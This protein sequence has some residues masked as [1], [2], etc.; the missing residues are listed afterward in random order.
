MNPIDTLGSPLGSLAALLVGRTLLALLPPGFPGSHRPS[1]LP[2]TCAASW[3]LG[4]AVLALETTLLGG[5]GG[6]LV[7]C[8]PWVPIATLRIWSL[9]GAMVPRHEPAAEP[10][11]VAPFVSATATLASLAILVGRSRGTWSDAV[12]LAALVPA[13]AFALRVARRAPLSRHLVVAALAISLAAHPVGLPTGALVGGGG[14]FALAWL[15]RADARGAWLSIACWTGVAAL[16]P[17]GLPLALGGLVA[18]CAATASASRR[19]VLRWCAPAFALALLAGWL[20]GAGLGPGPPPPPQPTWLAWAGVAALGALR[21]TLA[22]TSL[23]A[24]RIEPPRRELVYLTCAMAGG[25][26]ASTLLP[27][28]DAASMLEAT[29]PLA[30]LATGLTWVG[31]EH[32]EGAR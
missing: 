20:R 22:P 19:R 17:S 10:V 14:A 15:R 1:E 18:L 5:R 31:A 32:P 9:P 30:G 11:G 24:E 3:L 29:T 27:P 6:L 7:A 8:A 21:A 26:L 25:V 2:A 12:A 13:A 23:G 28:L 4:C 16:D